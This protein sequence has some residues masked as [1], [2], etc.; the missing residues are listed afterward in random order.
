[1]NLHHSRIKFLTITAAIA[2]P[3]LGTLAFAADHNE[4]P[5]TEKAIAILEPTAGSQVKGTITFTKV[6][7]GIRVEGVVTGLT[8]GKHGFHVHQFGDLTAPD[9]TSAGGHFNPGGEPH[10]GPAAKERHAGDF[11]NIDAG[12]DGM[13]KFAFTDT[14][15]SFEGDDSIL[16]RGVVVHAKADDMKSQPSGEAGG[17]VAVGVI[18]VAKK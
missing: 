17:R 7:D 1:M 9:G 8:P 6:G 18:G 14:H 13:S 10:G 3:L 2:A 16:G 5:K 12:A 4:T 11:G 15:I